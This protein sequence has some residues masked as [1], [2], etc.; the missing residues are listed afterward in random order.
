MSIDYSEVYEKITHIPKQSAIP[1]WNYAVEIFNSQ[2]DSQSLTTWAVVS[3]YD[4][5]D[6]E[7]KIWI[8]L[9]AGHI[10]R[11]DLS[12]IMLNLHRWSANSGD[13]FDA[14]QQFQ[15]EQATKFAE[16]FDHPVAEI[17]NQLLKTKAAVNVY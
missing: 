10:M 14:D 8:N 9:L 3:A 1:K 15:L 13:P 6:S 2:V 5:L 16:L 17:L 7:Q 12:S 4:F 11:E